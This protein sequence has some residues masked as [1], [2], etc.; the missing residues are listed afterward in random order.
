[1]KN[2]PPLAIIVPLHFI[3]AYDQDFITGLGECQTIV[4]SAGSHVLPHLH[5]IFKITYVPYNTLHPFDT[6]FL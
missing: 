4:Y 3:S 5:I 6:L 2:D 1:M